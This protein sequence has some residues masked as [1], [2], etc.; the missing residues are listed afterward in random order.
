MKRFF[1]LLVAMA[2]SAGAAFA[3]SDDE[4][5]RQKEQEALLKQQQKEQ[6]DLQKQQ[7]KEQEQLQKQQEREKQ[8]EIKREQD[9]QKREAAKAQNEARKEQKKEEQKAK[10]KENYAKWG[11]SPRVGFDPSVTVLTDR[12]MYGNNDL[13]N[14]VGFNLGV[15]FEYRRPIAKRWDFNVGLGYRW[16][17]YVYSHLDGAQTDFNGKEQT[18]S[19]SSIIVPIKLSH[20][21]KTNENGWY[22][23]VAPGFNF[24]M[25][26]VPYN[27]WSQFRCDLTVG[28][29]GKLLIFTPGT[30][31]YLNLI[32]T[33][34]GEGSAIHEFG[35]RITL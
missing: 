15:T 32:P 8:E 6:A 5:Q 13:Y 30:E 4:I 31:V 22:L 35:I 28:T 20:F 23:G 18:R 12:R 2:I 25:A 10:R 7:Q 26:S 3:Q 17:E 11:R 9:R 29:I 1:I 27:T 19:Y 24:G 33:Y 14:S 21:N 16:T 34:V